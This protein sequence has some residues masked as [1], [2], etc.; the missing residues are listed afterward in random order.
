MTR[1]HV[2]FVVTILLAGCSGLGLH[3]A[4]NV[5]PSA[6]AA[7]HVSAT[8]MAPWWQSVI[9]ALGGTVTGFILA[10]GIE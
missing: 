6:V 9:S 10:Q 7:A 1:H 5:S 3:P 8:P 4:A 2:V